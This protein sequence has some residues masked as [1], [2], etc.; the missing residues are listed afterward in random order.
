M[1]NLFSF[2]SNVSVRARVSDW[3]GGGVRVLINGEYGMIGRELQ[4]FYHRR[5]A[6]LILPYLLYEPR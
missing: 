5:Q 3:E 4:I 6:K 2:L 1:K